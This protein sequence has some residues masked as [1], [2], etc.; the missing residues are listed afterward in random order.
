MP[1]APAPSCTSFSHSTSRSSAREMSFSL[2]CTRRSMRG[3]S[4][5]KQGLTLVPNSA[6]LELFCPPYNLT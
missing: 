6:K 4:T 2:I 3:F 1:A 5:S